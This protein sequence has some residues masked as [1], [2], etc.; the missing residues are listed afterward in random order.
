[1]AD[2]IREQIARLRVE[3]AR[4][5]VVVEAA[6][7]IEAGW[8]ALVDEVWLVVATRDQAVERVVADRGLAPADVERRIANQLTDEERMRSADQVIRNTGTLADLRTAIERLW[9]ERVGQAT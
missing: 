2:D 3:D 9:R 8:N 4:S 1:M 7:L 6:V 5:P